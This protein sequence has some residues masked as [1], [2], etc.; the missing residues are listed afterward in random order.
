[1]V[2][3][4]QFLLAAAV[5]TG[6]IGLVLILFPALI[7]NLFL[8]NPAHGTDIFIRFLGSSLIGYTYLNW[9]TAKYN[10]SVRATLI[11]NFAT[12]FIALVISLIGVL[13]H[14]LKTTG[15]AIV[16]LHL[17]FAA[18]FGW[19]LFKTPTKATAKQKKTHIA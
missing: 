1:M 12:L 6:A 18:G 4:K 14:S 8:P 9:F 13:D 5:I 7:A 2:S 17:M 16:L 10:L 15:W 11:G 3:V 19:F